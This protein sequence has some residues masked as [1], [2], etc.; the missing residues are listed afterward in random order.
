[1]QIEIT[2]KKIINLLTKAVESN[3]GTE[4]LRTFT[5]SYFKADDD[6]ILESPDIE[7]F[8]R[9]VEDYNTYDE[10]FGDVNQKFTLIRLRD[11]LIKHSIWDEE[12]LITAIRY[13]RIKLL[14]LQKNE[15]ELSEE[16]FKS[17]LKQY[18]YEKTNIDKVL[19]YYRQLEKK[20]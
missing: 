3:V 11:V 8:F 16:Q 2:K 17:G 14:E 9:V 13:D 7:N 5:F 6:Y 18:C 20:V 19:F 4:E 15:G 10:A 12:L 1:M